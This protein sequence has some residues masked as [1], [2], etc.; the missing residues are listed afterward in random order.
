[1]ANKEKVSS[2]APSKNFILPFMLMLLSR[3]PLHGY[4]LNQKL[5]NF[6]FHTLDHGNLYRLLRKL[7][8]DELVN[9]EWDT[10]G[11]GPA[12][13]KY[14]ITDAGITYLKSYANQ[15]EGYQAML[16]QFFNM[17][18]SIFKLYIPSI[19]RKGSIEKYNQEEEND[20]YGSK[21]E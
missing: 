13:R 14:T 2:L 19:K 21:E 15:L 6:G 10:S 7:E 12:K 20:N 3:M 17:Y 11:A 4:E 18:S 5:Q 8:Q 9:S 1:M 16:D